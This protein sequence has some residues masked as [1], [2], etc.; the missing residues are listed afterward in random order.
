MVWEFRPI[1]ARTLTA[2]IRTDRLTKYYGPIMALTDVD[3]EVGSGEVF[4]YLGPNGAGKTTTIRILLDFIRATDGSASVFGLDSRTQGEEIRRRIGYLPGDASLYPKL[5][6]METLRYASHLRNGVDWAYVD[7]LAERFNC[8]LAQPIRSLSRGNRQK[9]SL[10]LA[11]MH[12]PELIVM[13]E[14]T[15]GLDPLIQQEFY[16]LVDEVQAEGCTVFLSSHVLP[17]VERICD[18]VAIVRDGRIAALEDVNELKGRAVHQFEVHFAS[19][20]DTGEFVRLPSVQ[21]VRS[22]DGVLHVAVT[23]SPDALI[24]AAAKH[25]VVRLV[26]H[27]PSL[28]DFFLSYYGDETVQAQEEDDAA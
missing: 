17:E 19:T 5:T 9:I 22:A 6:G 14:P 11:F 25:E 1:G 13:D 21:D 18:R 7:R 23:G 2:V 8:Q 24:K 15:S 4:G 26:S 16:R 10:V 27:E 20:V 28:E 3:L 12:R